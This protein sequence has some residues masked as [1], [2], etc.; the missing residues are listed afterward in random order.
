MLPPRGLAASGSALQAVRVPVPCSSHAQW[1]AAD[2]SIIRGHSHSAQQH[3]WTELLLKL[4]LA[5]QLG[6]NVFVLKWSNQ[7]CRFA[8]ETE[9]VYCAH[10][11]AEFARENCPLHGGQVAL[12]SEVTCHV[13]VADGA[14]LTGPAAPA[15][16]HYRASAGAVA[17]RRCAR[18]QQQTL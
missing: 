18:V 13:E 15:A 17:A 10:L 2:R 4:S 14:L 7:A 8:L 16:L 9:I 5:K 6:H 12:R 11:G 1:P 3:G